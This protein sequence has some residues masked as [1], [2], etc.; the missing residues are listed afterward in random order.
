MTVSHSY[1]PSMITVP[2]IKC[3]IFNVFMGFFS[4]GYIKWRKKNFLLSG[5]G[6]LIVQV[7]STHGWMWPFGQELDADIKKNK[8]Q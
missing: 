3:F 2:L 5:S 4:F 7:K 6:T 1:N 8:K